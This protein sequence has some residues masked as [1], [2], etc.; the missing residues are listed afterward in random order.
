MSDILFFSL[1][2]L[3]GSKWCLLFCNACQMS[4]DTFWIYWASLPMPIWDNVVHCTLYSSTIDF[5]I[6]CYLF[7]QNAKLRMFLHLSKK[8]LP[9]L[10]YIQVSVSY[11]STCKD[12]Y[13]SV[14]LYSWKVYY[15]L[16][17]HNLVDITFR[18]FWP[19][20]FCEFL[21]AIIGL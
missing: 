1:Q 18:G 16:K 19:F 15:A 21:I 6:R 5:K 20:E 12:M 7:A 17:N 4:I 11:H 14:P 3:I 10:T 13:I 9:S 8:N 2:L